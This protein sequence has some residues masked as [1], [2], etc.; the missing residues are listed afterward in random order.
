VQFRCSQGACL[1]YDVNNQ[2][3]SAN[4]TQEFEIIIPEN[5]RVTTDPVLTERSIFIDNQPIAIDN[6]LFLSAGLHYFSA[7]KGISSLKIQL[8]R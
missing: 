7:P 6:S 2:L 8:D 4:K 1:Q 5:Y 3:A